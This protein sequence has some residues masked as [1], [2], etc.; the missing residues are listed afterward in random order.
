MLNEIV[1]INRDN[2]I[3]LSLL[4]DSVA[5]SHDAIT[6]CQLQVGDTLLDS[7]VTPDLFDLSNNDKVILKLGASTLTAG[8]YPAKLIVFDLNN[9]LGLVWGDFVITVKQ[10]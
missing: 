1:Y 3:A 10:N 4:S 2:V 5:I 7:A 9:H 8:R 6:R